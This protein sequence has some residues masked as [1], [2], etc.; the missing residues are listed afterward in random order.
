MNVNDLIMYVFL[1]ILIVGSII[2]QVKEY[3]HQKDT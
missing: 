1:G 3:K 2:F